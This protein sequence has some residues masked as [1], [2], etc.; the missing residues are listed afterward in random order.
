MS[1][2]LP[3]LPVI[4]KDGLQFNLFPLA[5]QTNLG[6]C[7]TRWPS[8]QASFWLW[9][10]GR[11][12]HRCTRILLTSLGSSSSTSWPAWE[13]TSCRWVIRWTVLVS[14]V[15]VLS[16]IH[17][18][19]LVLWVGSKFNFHALYLA[20]T[21]PKKFVMKVLLIL[22]SSTIP[23]YAIHALQLITRCAFFLSL[24]YTNALPSRSSSP[25]V[26]FSVM[27]PSC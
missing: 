15:G 5:P 13:Q 22:S 16:L 14:L 3:C 7:E 8:T 2:G 10:R 17:F 26:S 25:T 19:S 1:L 4:N 9:G 23:F 24:L 6:I 20:S 18:C 27:S 21:Q 11:W 12:A